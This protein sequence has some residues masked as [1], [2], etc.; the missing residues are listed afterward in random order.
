MSTYIV[1]NNS[2]NAQWGLLSGVKNQKKTIELQKKVTKEMKKDDVN[3]SKYI[4]KKTTKV[5]II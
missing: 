4:V 1:S 2:I 3:Q 5:D